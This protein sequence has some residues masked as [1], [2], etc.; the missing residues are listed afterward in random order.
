MYRSRTV[1]TINRTKMLGCYLHPFDAADAKKQTA[2]IH[3]PLEVSQTKA[4]L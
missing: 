4:P 1:R 2:I 3:C